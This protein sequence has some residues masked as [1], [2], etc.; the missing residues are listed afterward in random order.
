LLNFHN[1]YTVAKKNIKL[2]FSVVRIPSFPSCVRSSEHFKGRPIN[3]APTPTNFL[4]PFFYNPGCIR[5]Q[6]VFFWYLT[7]IFRLLFATK[8][9]RT[10]AG[11]FIQ[12]F[13]QKNACLESRDRRKLMAFE[14]AHWVS[15]PTTKPKTEHKS[16]KIGDDLHP[17]FVGLQYGH[18]TGGNKTS[19]NSKVK[20]RLSSE[21]N[22]GCHVQ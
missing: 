12:S 11:R 3:D 2:K 17:G 15:T 5:S 21:S 22:A 19:R 14:S 7:V 18:K 8:K 13:V 6:R 1:T 20:H 4:V 9:N 10:Y 16:K